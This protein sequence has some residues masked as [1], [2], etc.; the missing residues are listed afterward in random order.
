MKNRKFV[1]ATFLLVAVMLLGVG[2]AVVSDTLDIQGTADV[3]EAGVTNTFNDDVY[4]TGIQKGNE[5]VDKITLDDQLGYTA[6]IDVQDNDMVHF[7]VNNVDAKDEFQTI[8]Y[9]IKNDS[10]ND[11][12]ISLKNKSTT[13]A[14][15]FD[16]ACELD[17][18]NTKT[19]AA[20]ETTTVWIKVSLKVDPAAAYTAA[21]TF[22]ILAEPDTGN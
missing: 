4:F 2:Y 3:S 22:G 5:V 18:D 15:K 11:V 14:E 6:H 16:I 21:F 12:I 19:I 9:V 17:N 10:T 20:G 1:V 8:T 7:T 13:E